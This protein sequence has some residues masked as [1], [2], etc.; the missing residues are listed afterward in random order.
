M[1]ALISTT[2]SDCLSC[3]QMIIV[4]SP[5]KPFQFT[6]KRQ[7]RRN[8]ILKAYN[9]EIEA[10][11]KEIENSSQSEFAAPAVWDSSSTLNFVRTVVQSTLRRDIGDVDDIF[12]NGGDR[13]SALLLTV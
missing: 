11:Y 12:R 1:L 5:S 13:Y 9:D 7:P 10:L 6:E 2:T 3:L 4:T 8:F